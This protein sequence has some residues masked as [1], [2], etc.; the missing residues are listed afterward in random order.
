MSGVNPYG[1]QA[2]TYDNAL[3]PGALG[4]AEAVASECTGIASGF[5]NMITQGVDSGAANA[6]VVTV[7]GG[8]PSGAYV[9]GQCV[10]FKAVNANTGACT[11]NVNSLGVVGLTNNTGQSLAAGAI[12]ANSWYIIRYNSVFSAFTLVAPTSLTTT[13]NTISSS[14]PTNKVG[15]T[16]AAG[17]ST[18]CVPIDITFAIDQSIIPTW[19]G[20]HTF[21]GGST[22]SAAPTFSAGLGTITGLANTYAVVLDGS[23]VAGQSYG[24]EVQAGTN[25]SDICALFNSQGGT[26][27]LK[28]LGEG[29][30]VAG[31]A[32]GGAQG[33]GTINAQGLYINGVNVNTLGAVGGNPTASVGLSAVNGS[34][35]T[36]LRSD[37]APALSVSIAPTWTGA[38]TFSYTGGTP[39]TVNAAA[40]QIGFVVNGGT[41]TVNTWLAEFTTGQGSGFSSG[42][43][44]Q[45]GTTSGDTSLAIN[46]A[47]G[48]TTYLQLFG[49]GEMMI[50]APTA[51][52]NQGT[53]FYQ[54]GYLDLPYNNQGAASYQLVMRDRGKTIAMTGPA[55]TLTIPANGTVGF[56]VG[57]TIMVVNS[58]SSGAISIA[59]TTDTLLWLPS[60]SS[61]TRTLAALSVATLYKNTSTQWLIWGFGLT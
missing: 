18:A 29:S 51:A 8:G 36:F 6:Y 37:G 30:I 40:N 13:T 9:D 57:T 17:A 14:A 23:A 10:E 44:I 27:R 2:Y 47:A 12:S 11:I 34:A 52:S 20:A 15:L 5:G 4:R 35:A 61:G 56:P 16:G 7:T 1:T 58:N 53:N 46:N 39:V 33:A 19:T 3:I 26:A 38:H 60:G 21:S 45:A 55:H 31:A 50:I 24:L 43:L 41:N 22:F 49:D 32:T 25:A 48:N 28:I 54:V 42:M 59:I